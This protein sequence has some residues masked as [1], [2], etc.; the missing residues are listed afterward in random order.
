M[1]CRNSARL[2][3][4]VGHRYRLAIRRHSSSWQQL[5]AAGSNWQQLAASSTWQQLGSKQQQQAAAAAAD[6]FI[7]NASC[8]V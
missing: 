7:S 3:F 2:F 6:E 1:F 5:A 8:I 4:E